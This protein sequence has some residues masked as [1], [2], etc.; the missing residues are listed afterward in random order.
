MWIK[1]KKYPLYEINEFGVVRNAL[2]HYVT[3][4]RMN[5]HGYLYVQLLD[6]EKNNTC[7]VHRLVAETFI[8]NPEN[9]PIVNH[10]DE[11]SVHNSVDNLE[12]VSYKENSNHGTRNERIVRERKI[13]VIAFDSYGDTCLR[14]PSRYDASR[15][16]GVSEHAVRA[17]MKNHNKCKNL[18]WRAAF[19]NELPEDEHDNNLEWIELT[20]KQKEQLQNKPKV[21][22]ISVSALDDQGNILFTFNTITEAA[23]Q[24]SVSGPAVSTAIR[25][26]TKCK[27]LKWIAETIQECDSDES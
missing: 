18:F 13:A 4:Q 22:I 1:L 26:G 21:K 6:G 7:L 3:T 14:Y 8:P 24:M 5:R 10:I 11:C 27:G 2:T 16:L 20:A 12:W 9:L 19:E 25:N 15:D 17:A 23:K